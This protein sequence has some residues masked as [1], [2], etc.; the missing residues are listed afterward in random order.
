MIKNGVDGDRDG[1]GEVDAEV[2]DELEGAIMIPAGVALAIKE[3]KSSREK[4]SNKDGCTVAMIAWPYTSD[5]NN[6]EAISFL[7]GLFVL[8]AGRK[9]LGPYF[10]RLVL[11]LMS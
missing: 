5:P 4:S 8:S 9:T 1:D 11:F 3:K 10:T 6:H 2:Q 7:L